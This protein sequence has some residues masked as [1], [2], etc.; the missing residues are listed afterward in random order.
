VRKANKFHL[1][2]VVPTRHSVTPLV[3][4]I[5]LAFRV[6]KIVAAVVSIASSTSEQQQQKANPAAGRAMIYE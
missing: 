6:V 1:I 4:S 5:Q 2:F 3:I